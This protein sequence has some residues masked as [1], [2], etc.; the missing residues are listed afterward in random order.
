MTITNQSNPIGT[1]HTSKKSQIIVPKEG[2]TGLESSTKEKIYTA[3]TLTRSSNNPPKYRQQIIQYNDAKSKSYSVIATKNEDTGEFDF[4]DN[5]VDFKNTDQG[6]FKKLVVDQ[7]KTQK[8]DAE[9]QIK[10][11]VNQDK[12]AINKNEADSNTT[13]STDSNKKQDRQGIARSNY[14]VLHYPAFIE[15]SEQDKLKITI[16]E[17]SSRFRGGKIPKSKLKSNRIPPPPQK[18]QGSRSRFYQRDLAA[19]NK[20]YGLNSDKNRVNVGDR[21][22][23]RLSLDNRSR[24][25][26]NKRTVGHITLPIPDGV[27]DQNQVNFTDG[28]LNPLQVAG[29]ET[30][31]K[32]FL[33]GGANEKAGENAAKAFNQAITDP[34]VKSA[35][36][37]II[38]GSVFGLNA[39]ELLARTEGN[40]LNNNLELLFK[41]PTLRPFNFSFNLS[42]RSVDESRMIKKIIRAFK[43]SSAVQKTPGGLFL[44]APN[45]YKLEFING[46]TNRKHEFL[47]R[48]KECA[49]LGV[50]MNYMPENTYMTYDDTSMVSYNMRLQFKELEPVFNDD[51]DKEDQSDTGV[52]RGSIA[53]S[54]YFQ[55]SSDINSIG[56]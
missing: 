17:F 53:A 14:G 4:I 41:G 49:L 27:S 8:K 43:Q 54:K 35:L 44:H 25:E 5:N 55:Q 51:Y 22:D 7:T 21:N 24:I 13:D 11:K 32:F 38:T 10:N 19:Y 28:R 3:V 34:N 20:K 15:R 1:T 39:N 46:K 56:F 30:A 31:L 33:R 48:V 50:S 16:L 9:K 45:T 47:P 37:A 23:S 6:A 26:A 52:R 29:A 12:K 2:I 18:A 36:S 40:V 42:A